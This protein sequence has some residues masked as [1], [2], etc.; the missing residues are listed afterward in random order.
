MVGSWS[1][2]VTGNADLG[3]RKGTQG[4]KKRNTGSGVQS[5]AYEP[6]VDQKVV[7]PLVNLD[8]KLQPVMMSIPIHRV[9]KPGSIKFK[10]KSGGE[11]DGYTIRSMNAFSNSYVGLYDD[12]LEIAENG[13]SCVFNELIYLQNQKAWTKARAEF[14][15]DLSNLTDAKKKELA[16][17]IKAEQ[18][19]HFI[20]PTYYPG[21]GDIPSR[22]VT[23]SQILLL[24]Y[25][26]IDK[27][28]KNAMGIE[29][30][31]QEVVLDDNGQ[32]KYTPVLFKLSEERAKKINDA[33]INAI[34]DDVIST[35]DLHPYKEF[36]GTEDESDVLIG[37]V[38]LN[39][40]WP[41]GSKME[42]GRNLAVTALPT[43]KKITTPEIIE[44]VQ[45]EDGPKLKDSAELMF[46]NRPSNI[47]R[48]RREQI[49]VLSPEALR[50]YNELEVEFS[51]DLAE[52][53]KRYKENVLDRVLNNSHNAKQD[54]DEA[55]AT[56]ADKVEA[57]SATKEEEVAE[58]TETPKE[59]PAKTSSKS[60]NIQDLL[61][62][63]G[64][65]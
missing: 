32:P 37:W 63:V 57:E 13:D 40:R 25:E 27:I 23:E 43:S 42:S 22:N 48:N 44:K 4:A 49:E 60:K 19:E 20:K 62:K 6:G 17:F 8:G 45:E 3:R 58:V 61:S 11:Y 39:L 18:D 16:E 26:T 2:K 36:E 31:T 9:A 41:K 15:E 53:R 38:D 46:F 7:V 47:V 64:K 14:G 1:R 54:T 29:K 56:D 21:N 34:N 10:S 5:H 59:T 24:Q 30:V 28:E 35:D 50:V 12:A 55:D 33:I 52:F 51:D 65:N